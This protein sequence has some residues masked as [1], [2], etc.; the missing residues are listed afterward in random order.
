M[1]DELQRKRER[2]SSRTFDIFHCLPEDSALMKCL[3]CLLVRCVVVL[4][5]A[6]C[7]GT[8]WQTRFIATLAQVHHR[9]ASITLSTMQEIP[10]RLR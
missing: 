8:L 1:L 4:A 6:V 5:L 10:T 2:E 9:S 7:A 3:S